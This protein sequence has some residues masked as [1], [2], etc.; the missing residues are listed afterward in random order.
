MSLW[1]PRLPLTS[2][3]DALHIPYA[4]DYEYVHI[5]QLVNWILNMQYYI[6][7]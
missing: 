7:I 6:Y 1:Q 2:I 4:C 5:E 3:A